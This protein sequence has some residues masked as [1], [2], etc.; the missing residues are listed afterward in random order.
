[1]S[2]FKVAVLGAR[3]SVGG[4]VLRQLRA[5][6]A[7][8]IAYTRFPNGQD[9]GGIKWRS[10]SR[11]CIGKASNYSYSEPVPN[12]ISVAPIW[13]LPDYFTLMEASGVRRLV[14]LSSTSV[15]TKTVS[16]DK[17]EN[18]VAEMLARSELEVQEWATA[19]GVEWVVLRPTLIYGLGQDRNVSEIARFICR[20]GFF[21]L[22]GPAHGLR[23]PV[24]VQDV[25][26]ACLSALRSPAAAN[27]AY[28]LSGGEV[29]QYREMLRRVFNAV[30]RP[31]R[32]VAVPLWAFKFAVAIGR[33]LL[34]KRYWST[35]MA[36]RMN[37]D[38]VFDHADAKRDL[39]FNPKNFSL[40]TNDLPQ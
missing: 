14:T 36:K 9:V 34:N 7:Q 20:F 16:S 18:A 8:V 5:E 4:C 40:T 6:G 29:L 33:K 31:E 11:I 38:L 28:N 35:D 39:G 22:L 21:P 1:M 30:G 13:I 32:T 26:T 27:R 23:Q 17:G 25:A 12:W 2:E 3:S 37:A 24:H 10:L 19:R 15:F